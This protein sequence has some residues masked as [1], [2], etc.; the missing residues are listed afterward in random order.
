MSLDPEL[1]GAYADRGRAYELKGDRDKAIADYRKSLS[2]KSRQVYDDKAKAAALQ[3][4]TALA[5][6]PRDTAAPGR[7]LSGR[8]SRQAERAGQA[9]K[10][11]ALVIGNGAYANVKALK[12]ADATPARSPRACGSSAST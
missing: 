2:L 10:R 1:A 4:L 3:H 5:A 8:P 12:N 7:G 9:E 6:V 11:V